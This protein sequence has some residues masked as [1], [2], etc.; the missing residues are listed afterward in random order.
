MCQVVYIQRLFNLQNENL[1]NDIPK[2]KLT[3]RGL[4]N[5]KNK[6][7]DLFTGAQSLPTR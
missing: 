4:Q 5:E 1:Q 3:M 6:T 2:C 7:G